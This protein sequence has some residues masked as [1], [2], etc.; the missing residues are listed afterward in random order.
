MY[1]NQAGRVGRDRGKG[2]IQDCQEGEWGGEEE[3]GKTAEGEEKITLY[4]L[5]VSS[6]H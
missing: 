6:V 5:L 1:A 4:S 3:D 2:E